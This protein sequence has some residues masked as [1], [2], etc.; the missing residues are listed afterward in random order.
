MMFKD[1]LIN[2]LFISYSNEYYMRYSILGKNTCTYTINLYMNNRVTYIPSITYSKTLSTSMY[3]K[4]TIIPLS[5][6]TT[7][8]NYPFE[9]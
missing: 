2:L 8:I 7:Q 3:A 1:P 4:S 5:N 6:P 9:I